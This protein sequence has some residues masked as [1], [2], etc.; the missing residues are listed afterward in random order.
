MLI[1]AK[2]NPLSQ[3]LIDRDAQECVSLNKLHTACLRYAFTCMHLGEET[4]W[5]NVSCL[6]KQ[7]DSMV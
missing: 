6:R 1:V 2:G 7:Q 4:K 5:T 3:A